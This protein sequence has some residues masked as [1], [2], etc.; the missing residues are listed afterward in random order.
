MTDPP[1]EDWDCAPTA[2]EAATTPKSAVA[3]TSRSAASFRFTAIT[4]K[5]AI[6]ALTVQP[7]VS[8][9]KFRH[10]GAIIPTM[11]LFSLLA[12]AYAA[13]NLHTVLPSEAV[14]AEER[15]RE[16]DGWSAWARWSSS[17]VQAIAA[18]M[19]A[20]AVLVYVT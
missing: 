3:P 17:G 2:A 9:A 14:A 15:S 7:W 6:S 12:L 8:N 11:V 18:L 19:T 4:A 1:I 20:A 13:R 10:L 16:A 5:I